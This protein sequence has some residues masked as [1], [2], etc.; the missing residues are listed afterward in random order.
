[1]SNAIAIETRDG[2]VLVTAGIGGGQTNR[3]DA[4]HQAIERPQETLPDLASSPTVL[5]SDALFP[6]SDGIEAAAAAGIRTAIQSGGAMRDAEVMNAASSLGV[7]RFLT[8]RR[9]FR[10]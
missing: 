5:V 8:G 1:M 6:F 9:H 10:R 7:T 3:I 4:V 2:D